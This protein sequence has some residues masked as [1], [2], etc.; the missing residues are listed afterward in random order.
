MGRGDERYFRVGLSAL[1]C[2][3]AGLSAAGTGPVARVLDL[4]CGHGRVL[5]WLEARFPEASLTASD[6]DQHGVDWCA[7]SFGAIPAPSRAEPGAVSL[8]GPFDLIWCGS[9]LTHLDARRFGD[10]LELFARHLAPGGVVVATTHGERAALNLEHGLLDYAL[11]GVRAAEVLARYRSSGF[12]YVDYPG[13]GGYGV[14][15]SSPT[16]VRDRAGALREVL[17]LPQGWDD[18]QDVFAFTEA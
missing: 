15:L 1:E 17:F 13:A 12:G 3:E 14:S 10:L 16:W 18:H 7:R 9:L 8:P 2:V 11:P 6:L 5:R 4:P